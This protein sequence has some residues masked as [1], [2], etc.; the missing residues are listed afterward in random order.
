MIEVAFAT[1]EARPGVFSDDEPA[2]HALAARGVRVHPV[3]W[4]RRDVRWTDYAAVVVRSTWDYHLRQ[5][6]LLR[7]VGELEAAGVHLENAPRVLRWNADKRYLR[8]VAR[9][10]VPVIP[11]RWLAAGTD[12]ATLLT[13]LAEPGWDDAVLKPAVSA[14][15]HGTVRV[16]DGVLPEA[17]VP[18]LRSADLLLQP[19]VPEVVLTGEWSLVFIDGVFTHAVRKW[20]ASGDFRVQEELGGRAEAAQPPPWVREAAA[21]ALAAAPERPLYARVDGVVRADAFL[22]MELE[23]LEPRLYFPLQPS[24]AE[25]FADT[26]VAR[27]RSRENA[28]LAPAGPRVP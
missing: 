16:R 13:M 20:P 6:E 28:C 17:A 15:A 5:P 3:P 14:S 8:E 7:W 21:R 9:Q 2:A 1:C 26:L 12:A 25:R 11:T 22:L 10:G 19:F 27:L 24:A 4:S 18:L 23:L